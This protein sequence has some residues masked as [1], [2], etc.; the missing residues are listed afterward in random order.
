[1][2]FVFKR[3]NRAIL[4]SIQFIVSFFNMDINTFLLWTKFT[5]LF[6]SFYRSMCIFINLHKY[7]FFSR[8]NAQS[9]LTRTNHISL[10]L[11]VENCHFSIIHRIKFNDIGHEFLSFF[12]S[13]INVTFFFKR[14]YICSKC[15]PKWL[16]TEEYFYNLEWRIYIYI[17]IFCNLWILLAFHQIHF[18]FEKVAWIVYTKIYINIWTR[19]DKPSGWAL[20][21]LVA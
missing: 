11:W 5:L 20:T 14:R 18:V 19:M 10:I 6:I 4:S 7:L 15:T 9:S 13:K 1:M 12:T 8:R 2:Y 21:V 3:Y 17:K 16:T